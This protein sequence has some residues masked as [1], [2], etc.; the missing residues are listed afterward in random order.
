MVGLELRDINTGNEWLRV[1]Y[2]QSDVLVEKQVVEGRGRFGCLG[3]FS[4]S[5]GK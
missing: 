3:A 2:S 4:R 5:G 1:D